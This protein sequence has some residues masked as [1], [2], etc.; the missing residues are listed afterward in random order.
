MVSQVQGDVD[1][2]L[3]DCA[4]AVN[5]GSRSLWWRKVVH[6]HA[7]VQTVNRKKENG[8]GALLPLQALSPIT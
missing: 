8:A 2:L 7:L 1:L 4:G 5:H 3:W 6:H